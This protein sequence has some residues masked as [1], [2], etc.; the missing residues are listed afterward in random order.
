M[1]MF[2]PVVYWNGDR[3]EGGFKWWSSGM[4]HAMML[5]NVRKVEL[6]AG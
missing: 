2:E 6:C 4:E 5:L 3:A 1:Y